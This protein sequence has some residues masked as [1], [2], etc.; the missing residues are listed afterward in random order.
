MQDQTGRTDQAH[1]AVVARDEALRAS[2][3]L[4]LE[5][6]GMEA[7]G[8]AELEEFLHV[9]RLDEQFLFVD[10]GVDGGGVPAAIEQLRRRGWQGI[11]GLM[12][13]T[14]P[15]PDWALPEGPCHVLVKPFSADEVLSVVRAAERKPARTECN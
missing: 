9:S 5:M 8:F 13:E 6:C 2:L 1:A 10:C 11:A 7:A 12:T 4:L 14:D 3:V 15:P